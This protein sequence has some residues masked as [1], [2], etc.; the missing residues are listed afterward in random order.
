MA[1]GICVSS[2]FL[3][4]N[5][6]AVLRIYMPGTIVDQ[7]SSQFEPTCL[8]SIACQYQFSVLFALTNQDVYHRY[9]YAK[10]G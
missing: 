2:A 1:T 6:S 4:I 5:T 9:H 3:S 10:D 7:K 8:V